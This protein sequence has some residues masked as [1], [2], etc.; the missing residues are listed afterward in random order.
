M[1]VQRLPEEEVPLP[2]RMQ[3]IQRME[4]KDG[5][6]SQRETEDSTR[7]AG[8]AKEYAETCLAWVEEIIGEYCEWNRL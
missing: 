5:N 7:K 4:R 6:N 8:D 3:R 1:P 2:R